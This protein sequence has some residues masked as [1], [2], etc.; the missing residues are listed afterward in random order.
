[1]L[2]YDSYGMLQKTPLSSTPQRE[3]PS[4]GLRR[5]V[6]EKK[7]EDFKET[8]DGLARLARSYGELR[9]EEMQRL[10][11]SASVSPE[12]G[13]QQKLLRITGSNVL[14]P[15]DSMAFWI[16]VVTHKTRRVEV[17]ASFER[18]PV[19]I[20]SDFQELPGGPSYVARSVIDYPNDE[21]TVITDNF[22]YE[23]VAR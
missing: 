7:M 13:Q 5:L 22:E 3:L 6:A 1:M 4:R 8:I 15:G 11:A 23:R 12:M 9:P 20:V 2:R 17:N 18:K 21:L 10:M 19:R 14:Q 16:D